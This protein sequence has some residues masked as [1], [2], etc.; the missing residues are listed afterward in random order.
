MLL[1]VGAGATGVLPT[2]A[3][4]ATL[5]LR[6][7]APLLPFLIVFMLLPASIVS[8]CC[9]RRKNHVGDA[10]KSRNVTGGSTSVYGARKIAIKFS[11]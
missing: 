2:E 10:V 5:L 4:L 9:C 7:A 8:L 6:A 1:L 11:L 3:T